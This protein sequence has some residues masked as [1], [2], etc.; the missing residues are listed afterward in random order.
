M[1]T[2]TKHDGRP[3]HHCDCPH[4]RRQPDGPVAHEHWAINRLVARAD[5]RSRRLLVGFL[6]QRHGRGGITLLHRSQAWIATP[7]FAACGSC[8]N[9][10]RPLQVGCGGPVLA[11]SGR[12]PPTRGREG[13]G[14]LA[15][16]CHGRRPGLRDEVD[17]PVAPHSP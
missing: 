1:D 6:A 16:G 5:E 11:A 12:R 15:G 8:T 17:P 9:R 14:E 10:N 2:T 3:M 4:C 7:L 13:L